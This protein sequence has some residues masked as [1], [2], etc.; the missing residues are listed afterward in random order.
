MIALLWRE[1]HEEL[2]RSTS[3]VPVPAYYTLQR[4]T[5]LWE[6]EGRDALA[7]VDNLCLAIDKASTHPKAK[8]LERELAQLTIAGFQDQVPFIKEWMV[9]RG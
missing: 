2:H 8:P 6:P 9:P 4:A 3:P 1:G 5:R 7:S